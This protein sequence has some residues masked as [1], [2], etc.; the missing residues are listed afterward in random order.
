MTEDSRSTFIPLARPAIDDATVERVAAVLRSGWLTTGE[1]AK[2]FESAL[3]ARFGGRPVRVLNSGSAALELALRIAGVGPGDEVITTPL[4]WA[5]T[6]N[7]ILTVGATPVFADVDPQ[8]RNIAPAAIRAVMT[9]RTRVLLPV[10]L[11]GLPADRDALYAIAAEGRLRVVEDAAQ[12]LGAN[13]RGREIGCG[14]DLVCFSFQANKNLTTGEGGCLVLD[15]A[16]EAVLCER[17]RLQG[18][19]RRDDGEY[20]VEVLGGKFNL[21]DIAAAIGLGQ[22]AALAAANAARRALANH[23]FACLDPALGCEPP[24]PDT[25]E[26]NWH[27]FQILL[28]LSRL[29]ASR[30][31][32]IARLHARGIGTGVHYPAL[33]LTTLYRRLGYREGRFPVAEDIARRTLTLPLYP[34]LGRAGVER[35]CETLGAV[36]R[37][38]RR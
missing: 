17:L 30:G 5:G 19:V 7:A 29:R 33:H 25:G 6:A 21:T 14:G 22:L 24:A 15:T 32:I 12:S 10:D 27:M 3:A 38:V 28:P 4:T 18:V 26:S 35:V 11:A 9:P 13:W 31:E 23:Y 34:A 37:E 8:S 20:D 2:A 36:L 16:A 1:Q